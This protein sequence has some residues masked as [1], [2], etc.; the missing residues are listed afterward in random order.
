[1]KT[2]QRLSKAYNNARIEYIDENSK[3]I[4]FSDCHQGNGSHQ[5]EFIKNRNVYMYALDQYYEEGFTLV[6]VGD[7]DELWEYPKLNIIKNAHYQVIQ[8]MKRF[9]N[10]NRLIMLYGNHNNYLKNPKYVEENYFKYYDDYRQ[11]ENDFFKG[12]EPCEALV[13]KNRQ[14]GQE[15][16]IIHG[17]QGDFANDQF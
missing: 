2:E 7:G 11:K 14:T 10:G 6:E 5:D 3:Y 9:F 4:F 1:M 13:L 12:L 16:F 15:I 8:S 17:Y